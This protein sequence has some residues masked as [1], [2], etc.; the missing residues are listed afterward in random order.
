MA[1]I[2][3]LIAGVFEVGW[4]VGFKV[5]QN[6]G[7]RI[8]GIIIAVVCMVFSGILLYLA[9]RSIPMGT[10]YAVWTGVGTAGTFLVGVIVF[11]DPAFMINYFGIV[12]IIAGATLLKLAH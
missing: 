9:Q 12:L 11:K 2:Y 3:L 4:P 10:A 7:T 8:T 5:A 1:W 6:P